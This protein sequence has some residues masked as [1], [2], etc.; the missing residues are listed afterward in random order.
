MPGGVGHKPAECRP[1]ER[2][3][4]SNVSESLQRL[5]GVLAKKGNKMGIAMGGEEISQRWRYHLQVAK[6]AAGAHED[7][8]ERPLFAIVREIIPSMQQ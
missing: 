2:G 3:P 4:V 8:P 5:R 6:V 7:H 1:F